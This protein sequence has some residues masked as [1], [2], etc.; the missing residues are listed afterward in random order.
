MKELSLRQ[1]SVMDLIRRVK[2]LK[3]TIKQWFYHAGMKFLQ[4]HQLTDEQEVFLEEVTDFFVENLEEL[5]EDIR[6][7]KKVEL[8]PIELPKVKKIKTK[9]ASQVSSN[10]CL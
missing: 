4:S 1:K 9:T 8:G 2:P 7:V 10:T 5:E 6:F 3:K